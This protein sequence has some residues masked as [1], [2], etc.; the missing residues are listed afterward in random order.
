MLIYP[1]VKMNAAH[2]A[3]EF[4]RLAD[5][6]P[7]YGMITSE[8]LGRFVQTTLRAKNITCVYY[9]GDNTRMEQEGCT[10]L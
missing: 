10:Q 8:S 9:H 2:I 1:Y 6:G 3:S 7:V 4:V 5:A